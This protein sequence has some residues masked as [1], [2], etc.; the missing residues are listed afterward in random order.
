VSEQRRRLERALRECTERGAP[1]D[2]VDL[3]PAIKERVIAQVTSGTPASRAQAS[4]DRVAHGPRRRRPL[5][6][7]DRPLGWVLTALSVLILGAG[8]YA[9]S[10]LVREFLGNGLPG[11]GSS[12]PAEAT[13]PKQTDGPVGGRM[14]AERMFRSEVPGV[15]GE[16]LRESK[17]A[18]G[19]RVTLVR[20]HADADSVVVAFTLEDLRGGRRVDGHPAELQPGF[21]MGSFGVRL[22][23]ESGTEFGFV[24]GG[25]Q[26][27]SGPNQILGGPKAHSVV[28][29]PEGGLEP[30]AEHRFRLEIPVVAVPVTRLGV[31]SDGFRRVGEPLVFEFEVPVQPARVVEVNEKATADNITLK[32]E[33]VT[34]SPGQPEA[35]IC[36]EPREGVRSWFPGGGDLSYEGFK[37]LKGEGDCLEMVLRNGPLAGPSS[38][39]V[40]QVELN[41]ASDGEVIRG[42][43]TFEFEVPEP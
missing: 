32:L 3:W 31:D 17:S 35:V 29:R 36:M 34:D 12:G 6:V 8:V 21:D 19:A 16:K 14:I 23:D 10:G 7:P 1:A 2:T 13:N 24:T 28:Y 30:D 38:L 37:W 15:G 20:A 5:L 22:A 39:T 4:E 43:W 18:G 27:S 40:E 11:P 25:G 9:A 33:R 42:P 26:V 41:P